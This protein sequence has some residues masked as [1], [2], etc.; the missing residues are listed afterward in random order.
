MSEE[1]KS[2]YE[3]MKKNGYWW[4]F[5]LGLAIMVVLIGFYIVDPDGVYLASAVTGGL[6]AAFVMHV[7]LTTDAL[8]EKSSQ[9]KDLTDDLCLAKHKVEQ[10]KE[11]L[12]AQKCVEKLRHMAHG[13]SECDEKGPTK[14][15]NSRHRQ[16]KQN[17]NEQPQNEQQS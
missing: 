7:S 8:A 4:P 16:R 5:F 13:A 12:E 17:N 1:V 6:F 15:R 14:P 2:L 11:E 3:S 9:I 10:L